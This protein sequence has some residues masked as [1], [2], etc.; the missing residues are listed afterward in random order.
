MFGSF[1]CNINFGDTEGGW[2]GGGGPTNSGELQF[3][4]RGGGRR[5]DGKV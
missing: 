4:I 2:D 3:I 5:G 1:V